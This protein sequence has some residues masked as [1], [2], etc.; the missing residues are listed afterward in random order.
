MCLWMPDQITQYG[1]F[2]SIITVNPPGQ[3]IPLA[4]TGLV[5]IMKCF[6]TKDEI[7]FY[8]TCSSCLWSFTINRN[9]T[10]LK[11][12]RRDRCSGYMVH[13]HHGPLKMGT[14]YSSDQIGHCDFSEMCN[15]PPSKLSFPF[16]P[17]FL[18]TKP[19]VF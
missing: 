2:R 8:Y 7:S 6:Y 10:D 9:L 19:Q 17:L 5:Q 4:R 15:S 12:I 16:I 18:Q 14:G 1:I 11:I 13:T 3:Q